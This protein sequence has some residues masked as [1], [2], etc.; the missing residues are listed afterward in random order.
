M[1]TAPQAEWRAH[2]WSQYRGQEKSIAEEAELQARYQYCWGDNI[3][4][5][6]RSL[7]DEVKNDNNTPFIIQICRGYNNA[8]NT[9]RIFAVQIVL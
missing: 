4:D 3:V 5:P 7:T 6:D 1:K 9:S 2:L 8:A